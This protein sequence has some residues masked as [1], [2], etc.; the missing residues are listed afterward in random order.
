VARDPRVPALQRR[1]SK[2]E[3]FERDYMNQGMAAR[4]DRLRVATKQL[5]LESP[6][7]HGEQYLQRF[8]DMF[9]ITGPGFPA[10][11]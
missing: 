8:V 4:V 1:V 7:L 10:V 6:G 2:L 9:T 3:A 11:C 5:T